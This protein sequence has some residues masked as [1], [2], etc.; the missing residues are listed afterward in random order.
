MYDVPL[1]HKYINGY[2]K[3]LLNLM[4]LKKVTYHFL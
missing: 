1:L 4:Y 2:Y 3:L